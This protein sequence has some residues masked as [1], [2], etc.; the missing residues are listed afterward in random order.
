M[1]RSL[2]EPSERVPQLLKTTLRDWGSRAVAASGRRPACGVG[3]RY[4]LLTLPKPRS[5]AGR[6]EDLGVGQSAFYDKAVSRPQTRSLA[7]TAQFA[8]ARNSTMAA[9]S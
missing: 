1:S 9:P 8:S 4:S 2:R 3:F 7:R 6:C 5:A